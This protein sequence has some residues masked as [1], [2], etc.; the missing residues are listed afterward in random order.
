MAAFFSFLK[1]FLRSAPALASLTS[2]P[3][4][5]RTEAHDIDSLELTCCCSVAPSGLGVQFEMCPSV[6]AVPG[7]RVPFTSQGGVFAEFCSLL[8]K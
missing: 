5:A 2:T 7:S 4:A 8:S 3:R 1:K 6:K